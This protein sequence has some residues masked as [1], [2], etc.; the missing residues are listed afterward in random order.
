MRNGIY[1]ANY[2]IVDGADPTENYCESF[3]LYYLKRAVQINTNVITL[4]YG[5]EK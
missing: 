1:A 3:A 2:G 5:E 4:R